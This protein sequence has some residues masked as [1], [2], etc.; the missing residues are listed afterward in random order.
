MLFAEPG[1]DPGKIAQAV[2]RVHRIGQTRPTFVHHFVVGST[3]EENVASF[4][5][6]R[7]ATAS[8]ALGKGGKGGAVGLT[9]REARALLAE[10]AAPD[11]R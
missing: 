5:R 9:V 6:G 3:V 4:A 1:L 11:M 2:G 10:P 8:A 7:A